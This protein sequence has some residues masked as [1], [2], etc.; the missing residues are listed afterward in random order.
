M[1][2][3]QNIEV[4]LHGTLTRGISS[5]VLD[6]GEFK[7]TLTDGSVHSLGSLLPESSDIFVKDS[8]LI[9]SMKAVAEYCEEVLS[10]DGDTEI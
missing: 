10:L 3:V 4:E 5:V 7:V 9:P 8:C 2:D 1:T 6:E